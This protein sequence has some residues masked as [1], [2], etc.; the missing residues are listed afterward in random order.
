MEVLSSE[1]PR[2]RE[3]KHTHRR[4]GSLTALTRLMSK[5]KLDV[6]KG[7][8]EVD[9]YPSASGGVKGMFNFKH[10]KSPSGTPTAATG[11]STPE[12]MATPVKAVKTPSPKT[13]PADKGSATIVRPTV[14]VMSSGLHLLRRTKPQVQAPKRKGLWR[15]YKTERLPHLIGNIVAVLVALVAVVLYYLPAG[16]PYLVSRDVPMREGQSLRAG[17]YMTACVG[18]AGCKP[19][20]FEMAADGELAL[21][22][23]TAPTDS[24]QKLWGSGTGA[25]K[26][27]RRASSESDAPQMTPP[28][29]ALLREGKLFI[30]QGDAVVWKYPV[31][32]LPREV[33]Q[34]NSAAVAAA[35]GALAS[36]L[37]GDGGLKKK[38]RVVWT[39]ELDTL[40]LRHVN[41]NKTHK[42]AHGTKAVAWQALSSQLASLP[43][44]A[45]FEKVPTASVQARFESLA[46]SWQEQ[47]PKYPWNT[48][49][50]P[51]GE[52]Y[53]E[54]ER[55]LTEVV[56]TIAKIANERRLDLE[57]RRIAL[58]ERKLQLSDKKFELDRQ[59]LARQHDVLVR[60]VS[61]FTHMSSGCGCI[62][63]AN[64]VTNALAKLD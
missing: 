36:H 20:Y 50:G 26:G 6:N 37:S 35:A 55:A 53:E 46:K 33:M 24:R 59:E 19:M 1:S 10:N 57:E 54:L 28:P 58:E 21:Y 45:Q 44:F 62:D 5:S 60:L 25:K 8:L 31:N 4:S 32:R 15:R 47:D 3:S 9:V 27:G 39:R 61:H 63:T 18:S 42:A 12:P 13:S 43:E 30:M 41:L 56:P 11:T 40:L 51:D 49:R 64:L 38:T 17:E 48:T 14:T 16:G 52:P 7:D 2:S 34:C 23:G 22:S 29:I